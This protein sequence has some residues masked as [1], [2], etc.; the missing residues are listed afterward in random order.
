[1]FV[2]VTP[3]SIGSSWL[4]FEPGF[5]YSRKMRVV[6]VALL[7]VDLKDVAPPL[8]LL[9]GFNVSSASGLNN[10]IAVINQTL[11]HRHAESFTEHDY[12]RIVGAAS[13]PWRGNMTPALSA[14]K[15][16]RLHIPSAM[17]TE[18]LSASLTQSNVVH[19]CSGDEISLFGASIRLP[20]F[21]I[22]GRRVYRVTASIIAWS[23][24]VPAL[25]Q[26]AASATHEQLDLHIELD[27]TIDSCGGMH[28][29][30]A[31]LAGTDVT[32]GEGEYLEYRHARFRVDQ[33][34][35]VSVEVQCRT[36]ELSE[37]PLLDLIQ[38]LFEKKVLFS[39]NR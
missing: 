11:E 1:M 18:A 2:F 12:E 14:V 9:Q 10:I 15:T 39:P 7:G 33:D 35:L 27:R 31:L 30:S 5:A 36:A 32:L 8:S 16:V 26:V 3:S 28:N 21:F 38:L 37:L 24:V 19:R 29:V 34:L 23:A 25:A 20:S 22:Q 17:T 4:F 13:V 6:P